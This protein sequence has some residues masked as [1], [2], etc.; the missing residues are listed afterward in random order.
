MSTQTTHRTDASRPTLWALAGL[1]AAAL[2]SACGGGE[3][4]A[5]QEASTQQKKESAALARA[6]ALNA[7]AMGRIK[8]ERVAGQRQ[9]Q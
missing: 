7:D 9:A 4:A 3:D 1:L 2:S 5:F 6:H 8:A